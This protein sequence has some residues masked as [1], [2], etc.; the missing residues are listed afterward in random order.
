MLDET[1]T[2]DENNI[3]KPLKPEAYKDVK[4]VAA[5]AF[6]KDPPEL[7]KKFKRPRRQLSKKQKIILIIVGVLVL[8]GG[9]VTAYA[10]TRKPAPAA[11]TQEQPAPQEEPAKDTVASVTTGLQVKPAVNERVV[12][13]IMIENSPD[14]RPQSG[15]NQ[16]DIV[17]EAVAEGGITRFLTLFHDNQPDYIGPVRSARPYYLDW[18]KPF[19]APLAHAGGSA[20]ALAQIRQQ[21]MRD[22]EAFQNAGAYWRVSSRYAPHNLY[23]S[24]QKLNALE[25]E[26]GWTES[27]FDSWPRKEAEAPEGAATAKVIDLSI[28]GVLYN[29]KYKFDSKTNTYKRFLAGKPH[30]DEKSGKQLTPKV[31][32]TLVMTQGANGKYTTYDTTG[33]GRMFV[34]QDGQR[35]KGTWKKAGRSSQFEFIDE[36]GQPIQLNPGQTWVNIVGSTGAIKVSKQ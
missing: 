5:A 8:I 15:L 34:F 11:L 2:N 26:K 35:I 3:S 4:D 21:K 7:A 19:N 31:V 9:G 16:A 23:T 18:V 1:K 32:I 29:V 25:K 33:S 30:T 36:K 17:F 6:Q 13:G 28:S 10:M 24:I 27:K 14:A 12:T 20:E 22:L